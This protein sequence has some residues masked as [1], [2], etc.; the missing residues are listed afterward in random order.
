[1]STP[2]ISFNFNAVPFATIV[3][4][5]DPNGL[6]KAKKLISALP[7]IERN[8]YAKGTDRFGALLVRIIKRAMK[9]GLPPGGRVSWAPLAEQTLK[10]Y[11][12]TGRG[13]GKPW[14][15][16]GQMYREIGIQTHKSRGKYV[17]FK[18]NVKAL[19]I[20]NKQVTEGKLTI[21][22]VA[23]LLE[24]GT[25]DFISARP[26]FRPAF[27]EAGGTNKLTRYIIQEIRKECNK[28]TIYRGRIRRK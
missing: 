26:L 2:K 18:S 22:R 11:E 15:W 6:R 27:D 19:T 12:R 3:P 20:K 23:N 28:Y 14:F 21:N 16:L 10:R 7:H 8:A 13:T 1:M 4:Y 24:T 9:T 25:M 5:V 17:G